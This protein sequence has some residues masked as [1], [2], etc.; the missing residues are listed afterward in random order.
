MKTKLLITGALSIILFSCGGKE[1]KKESETKK[2]EEE[3]V[4]EK[5]YEYQ[6]EV[7][8]VDVPGG[9]MVSITSDNVTVPQIAEIL[10]SSYSQI[11]T[12]LTSMKKEMG[13]P[14]AISHNWVSMN[15]PFTLEAALPVMDSTIKVKAPLMLKKSY[16]G[17]ALKVT[18]FGPYENLSAA[19]MDIEQFMKENVLENNGSPWEVYIGDPGV[20]K[21]PMKVQTDVYMPIK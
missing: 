2:V 11:V 20:E 13:I 18:Y 4:E 14:M 19:Y 17:K 16:K 12:A 5:K 6:Y 7:T 15:D 9:W 21:D 3:K 1:E 8:Q 10:G